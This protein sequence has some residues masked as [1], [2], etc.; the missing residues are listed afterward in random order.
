MH[1]ICALAGKDLKLL[2]RDRAGFF[3]TFIFPVLF[4][5]F[6][7]WILGGSG[8]GVSEKEKGIAVVLVD[9]DNSDESRAFLKTLTDATELR[10]H[11]AVAKDAEAEVQNGDSVAMIRV[12]PG[13]GAGQKNLFWRG[14]DQSTIEVAA[15]PSKNAE[16][17]MLQGVLQKYAFSSMG[18]AFT[19]PAVSRRQ[20]DNARRQL[21][22]SSAVS[23]Q[24]RQMF[25]TFFGSLDRFMVGL[26]ERSKREPGESGE[27]GSGVFAFEPVKIVSRDLFP[28]KGDRPVNR[29]TF[30]FPQGIV[31]GLMGAAL[32][33]A[34]SL[35]QER[36][37]GTLG[38]LSVSPLP[39]WG[40][41]AGKGLACFLT[42]L[43]V[44]AL[45]MVV[46]VLAGGVTIRHPLLLAAGLVSVSVGFVGVMTLIAT[47]T[48]TER[49]AQGGG[50]GVMMIFAFVGGA[51]IP[52]FVFPPVLQKI[53]Q[54]SPMYWGIRACESGLWR[55]LSPVQA[56]LPIALM[57]GLGLVGFALGVRSMRRA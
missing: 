41:L 46:A 32:G 49:A 55:D 44:S 54:I 16:V 51:A 13:F 35:H 42:M 31:W 22:A 28:P 40:V 14:G 30:T 26:D 34:A 9:D 37:G 47:L 2:L 20:V 5:L 38:R 23:P 18:K 11:T 4:A 10:A 52:S 19:D 6:F 53:S 17:G 50:W 48:R 36:S 56:A 45:L 57:L 1:A 8:A 25:D 29:F 7:G 15:D 12:L 3:F 27:S 21:D 39:A 24:D 43:G 33:F